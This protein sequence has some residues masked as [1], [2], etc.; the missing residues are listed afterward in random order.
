MT[1][2]YSS[3]APRT[4]RQALGISDRF[5]VSQL[6]YFYRILR[7]AGVD[8]YQ[9]RMALWQTAFYAHLYPTTYFNLEGEA[10]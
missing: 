4:H 1:R 7:H 2:I 10:R 9:A 8:R 5:Q 3:P 6:R